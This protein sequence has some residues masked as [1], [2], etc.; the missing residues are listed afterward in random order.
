MKEIQSDVAI[1]EPTDDLKSRR[2]DRVTSFLIEQSKRDVGVRRG[3]LHHTKARD[4][5]LRESQ[6]GK[7][8]VFDRSLG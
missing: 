4:K 8:E 6:I 5:V 3:D 2:H 1:E 7:R